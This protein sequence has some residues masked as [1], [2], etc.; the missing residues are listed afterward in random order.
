MRQA[1]IAW[2]A[3]ALI[4]SISVDHPGASTS[5]DVVGVETPFGTSAPGSSV[6]SNAT[7]ASAS[8]AGTLVAATT[9]LWYLNNTNATGAYYARLTEYSATGVPNLVSFT[10]GINNGTSTPEVTGALGALT[11]TSGPYVR[12]EPASTNTIY[13][14]QAVTALSSGARVDV[15]VDLSDDAQ[16]SATLRTFATV[17]LT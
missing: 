14:T 17:T 12:L 8:V 11:Q 15:V 16:E 5:I 1:L 10:L 9:T 6:G 3:F 2:L 7:N 4:G 13:V